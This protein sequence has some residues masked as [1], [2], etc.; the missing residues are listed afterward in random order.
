VLNQASPSPPNPPS[1][2]I[3]NFVPFLHG[4]TKSPV[5]KSTHNRLSNPY[6]SKCPT[7]VL[8][9]ECRIA[10]RRSLYRY[11]QASI[12]RFFLG[13]G[14]WFGGDDGIV[15]EELK[16]WEKNVEQ[17]KEGKWTRH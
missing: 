7:L 3:A 4:Q 14:W 15:R 5:S 9:C 8:R 16:R 11:T 1:Q 13:G 17:E 2:E 6:Q 12:R 10:P